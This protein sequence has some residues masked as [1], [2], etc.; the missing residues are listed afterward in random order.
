M[1]QRTRKARA[2]GKVARKSRNIA[3]L[4]KAPSRGSLDDFI[5]AGAQSLGLKIDKSWMPAIRTHLE[6]T[7]R[8]GKLV[9]EFPLHDEA[10][11]APVFEA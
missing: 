4:S 2:T 8:H 1:T 6:V 10:E 5:G 11:P 9:A 7:L 3:K